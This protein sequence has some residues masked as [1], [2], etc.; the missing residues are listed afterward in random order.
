MEPSS[1]VAPELMEKAK[2]MQLPPL[3]W[4]WEKLGEDLYCQIASELNYFNPKAEPPDYR[5]SLDPTPFLGL[6]L[7]HKTKTT[8]E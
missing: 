2:K 1:G 8:E 6:I 3:P 7:K 5:P 4:T